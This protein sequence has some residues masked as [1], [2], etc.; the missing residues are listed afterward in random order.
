MPPVRNRRATRSLSENST[1]S[2]TDPGAMEP[3]GSSAGVALDDD[4]ANTPGPG[5]GDIRSERIRSCTRCRWVLRSPGARS[6]C[7]S[8]IAPVAAVISSALVSSNGNR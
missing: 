8:T 7:V 1:R 4:V 6:M 2:D 3:S 5:S